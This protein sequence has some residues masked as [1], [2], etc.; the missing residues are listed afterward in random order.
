MDRQTNSCQTPDM[1]DIFSTEVQSSDAPGLGTYT[2]S[3][4]A[5]AAHLI[6][7][8]YSSPI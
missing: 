4:P 1:E 3:G 7:I 6:L 5:A 8:K 2:Q